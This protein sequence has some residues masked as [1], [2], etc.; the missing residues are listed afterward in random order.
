MENKIN[1]QELRI[2]NYLNTSQGIGNVRT[3]DQEADGSFAGVISNDDDS[4]WIRHGSAYPDDISTLVL[5]EEL[6]VKCGFEKIRNNQYA[7][8]QWL[9]EF[10]VDWVALRKR[11]SESES[12]FICEVNYM[13]HFQN[14]IKD[15][16]GTEL[17]IKL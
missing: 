12:I 16:T 14:L 1:A 3:I 7:F 2:G 6:L 11:I 9:V 15:L 13:H 8:Q 5:S 17:E 4:V 10:L